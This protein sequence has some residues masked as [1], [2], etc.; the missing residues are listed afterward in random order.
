[1]R[2][3][4]FLFTLL[5]LSMLGCEKTLTPYEQVI[6]QGRFEKDNEMA[7]PKTTIIRP[8]DLPKFTGLQYFDVDPNYRFEVALQPSPDTLKTMK[9]PERLTN[10]LVEYRCAGFV[11]LPFKEGKQKLLVF[12][13]DNGEYW[14]PF[15]DQTSGKETYGGGRYLNLAPS[16]NQKLIVDFNEAYNPYCDYNPEYICSLPPRENRLSAAIRA[17]EKKSGLTH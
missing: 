13:L 15:T 6:I 1:M 4:L 8:V 16:Q 9:L 14:I 2:N 3:P 17:G 10:K 7:N 12:H 5:F 11:E